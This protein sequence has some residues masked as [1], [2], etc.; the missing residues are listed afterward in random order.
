M[1][2][3]YLLSF[4]KFMANRQELVGW[5]ERSDTRQAIEKIDGFAEFI[6][7]EIEGL[8]PSYFFHHELW[9]HQYYIL[10]NAHYGL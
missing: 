4:P 1:R 8:H 7:S 10:A 9:K 3:A 5:V 2:V 6:L